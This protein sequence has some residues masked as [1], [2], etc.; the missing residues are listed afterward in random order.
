MDATLCFFFL[1]VLGVH[2]N[3]ISEMCTKCCSLYFWRKEKKTDQTKQ[4]F[5]ALNH[6]AFQFQL[7]FKQHIE[8]FQLHLRLKPYHLTSNFSHIRFRQNG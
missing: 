1:D 3:E 6:D 2:S 4:T 5:V 7:T 8:I